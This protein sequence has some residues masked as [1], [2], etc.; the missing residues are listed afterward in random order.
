MTAQPTDP[1]PTWRA[2]EVTVHD[3][4]VYLRLGFSE[5][6]IGRDEVVRVA[7]ELLAAAE[8]KG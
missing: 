6:E 3:A 2:P 8:V 7:G 4:K 1:T 5:A